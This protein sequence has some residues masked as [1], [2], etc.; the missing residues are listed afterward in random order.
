MNSNKTLYSE[1]LAT[2]LIAGLLAAYS[3]AL[4]AQTAGLHLA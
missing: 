2:R 1:A 4:I 3:I